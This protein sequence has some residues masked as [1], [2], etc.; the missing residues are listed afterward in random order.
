MLGDPLDPAT[1][2]GPLSN[3]AVAA[4]MDADVADARAKGRR[5]LCGGTREGGRPTDFYYLL[6]SSTASPQMLLFR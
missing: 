5:V 6:P 1:N 3:E 4:K 2:L